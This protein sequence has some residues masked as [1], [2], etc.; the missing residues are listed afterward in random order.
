MID[1]KIGVV[2]SFICCMKRNR[3]G[4]IAL[5]ANVV[6]DIIEKGL[7]DINQITIGEALVLKSIFELSNSE[8]TAVFFRRYEL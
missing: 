4:E 7:G 2:L 5:R 3:E 6:R 1:R 8:A